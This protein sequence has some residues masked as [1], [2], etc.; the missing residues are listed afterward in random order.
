MAHPAAEP[1]DADLRDAAE[2][3][4][5]NYALCVITSRA[6]PD[7]RDG[8][9]PVQRRILYAMFQNLHLDGGVTAAQVGGDRRRRARQV[10]PARR[11]RG[12][13]G[14]GAH[15]AAVLARYPLVH[16]EGN[17]GSLDGDGAA[18]YALHRGPPHRAR[19]GDARRPRRRHRRP[20]APTTTRRS[21]SRSSCRARIPQLLMN[22]S[23]GIAVGMATNIPPHNLSEIVAALTAM[24]D[25]PEPRREG[26]P[27]AR[28]GPRLPDRR[29]DPELE[30][31][32]PRDLRERPGR[33]PPARRVQ[34]RDAAAR[35]APGRRHLDPVHRQQGGAGRADRAA[36]SS[37][38]S[39]RR[40]ST[41]ATSRPPTCAS[42]S[43]SRPTPRPRWRWRTSTSTPLCRRTSTST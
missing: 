25:E 2:E 12:L 40:S 28:Q 32:A 19:R 30:E 42:C 22:G 14:D 10:P 26:A 7:V 27:Q 20:S 16:G 8:L 29:R 15:G 39:C 38:A 37:R 6:L 17:F 4:Y 18:A 34:A 35:Q 31:G 3:R 41:C 13:R 9:K 36:R 11:P 33:D 43:S 1:I 5:L 24:I 21:T 23:T